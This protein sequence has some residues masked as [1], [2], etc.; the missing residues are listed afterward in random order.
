MTGLL[1]KDVTLVG[2]SADSFCSKLLLY[3]NLCP[4]PKQ[5]QPPG[6]VFAFW[7]C[8]SSHLSISNRSLRPD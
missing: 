4:G 2:S 1:A 6:T 5:H 3:R 8:D 7:P